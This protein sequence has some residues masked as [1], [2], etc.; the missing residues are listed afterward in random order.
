MTSKAPF[1][2]GAIALAAAGLLAQTPP[3]STEQGSFPVEVQVVTVDAVV[4]DKAHNPIRGLGRDDFRIL[5]DGVPQPITSFEAVELPA[6]PPQAPRPTRSP[7]STNVSTEKQ[8]G[9]TFAIVFDNIHLTAVQ[10]FRAKAAIGEFLKSSVR[11]GDRITL[12]STGG[13]A[14]WSATMPEGR[15][16]LL[17]VLKR[18]DGRYVPDSSPDQMTEYEAMRIEIYQDEAV[19]AQVGRRFDSYGAVGRERPANGPAAPDAAKGE[20]GVIESPVRVRASEVY[21][22]SL[23]RN[24]ITLSVIDRALRS[25]AAIKGRKAMILASQG[26]VFDLELPE[27]KKVVEASRRVNVPIYFVNTRGLAGLPDAM[28][29]AF[30][31]PVDIQDFVAVLADM[32]LESMGTESIALDTGGFV[33]KN[34]NDLVGGL[35][36]ISTESQAYYLL[37]YN[38]A[39]GPRDGKFRKIQVQVVGRKGLEVRARRGYYAPLEGQKETPRS[40]SDLD[41]VVERALNSPFEMTEV[42]LRTTAYIFDETILGKANVTLLTEADVRNLAFAAKDGRQNET[43]EFRVTVQHRESGEYY[44]YGQD[45]EMALLPATREKLLETWYPITHEFQLAPGGYQARVVVRDKLNGRVGSVIHDFEVPEL[46]GLRVSTPILTDALQEGAPAA[47][48]PK[49]VLEARREFGQGLTL[50]CQYQ[51]YGAVKDD[52]SKLPQV[53]AAYA[54]R[55][56]DGTVVK[57]APPTRVNP[58]SLG[59]LARFLGLNLSAVEPGTYDLV[60]SVKDEVAGKAV[61]V[62]EPFVIEA[63]PRKIGQAERSHAT[64]L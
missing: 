25:L 60:L 20:V 17:A 8:R 40:P 43:L 5:Q 28:T 34:S 7:I 24:K 2:A 31:R 49:P 39:P 64:N 42:P 55:R 48:L 38:P 36:R 9:R 37:G 29:A 10:A 35:A 6:S 50:Y 27:M 63:A 22:Q 52:A 61:E 1:V 53:S 51:V 26:F 3:P 44:T 54:V 45:V 46:S 58:T 23:T 41:P 32:S 13:E 56:R 18:L 57:S 11:E 16:Q 59:S 19:A 62:V 30:G 33:V 4:V 12:L 21:T 15:D 47:A 14:W